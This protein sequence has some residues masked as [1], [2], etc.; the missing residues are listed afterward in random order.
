MKYAWNLFESQNGK[1]ALTGLSMS[2]SRTNKERGDA[3]MDRTD[4]QIG[5]VKGNVRWVLKDLNLMKRTLSYERLFYY[6]EKILEYQ[7]AKEKSL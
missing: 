7:K 6:C 1:C 4:N 2:M 3:S 5:Y